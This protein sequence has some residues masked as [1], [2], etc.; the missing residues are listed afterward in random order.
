LVLRAE[1]AG[2]E[3]VEIPATVEELRATRTSFVRRIPRTL[4]GLWRIRRAMAREPR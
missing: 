1:R 3:I 2:Y 4:V